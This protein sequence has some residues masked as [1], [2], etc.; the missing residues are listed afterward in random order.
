MLVF[1]HE[2]EQ[3]S[4]LANDK[5]KE[6]NE[7]QMQIPIPY[8]FNPYF[9][10]HQQIAYSRNP[11]E[12]AFFLPVIQRFDRFYSFG[13]SQLMTPTELAIDYQ[14]GSLIKTM[15]FE[16]HPLRVMNEQSVRKSN[17]INEKVLAQF[18]GSQV[19]RLRLQEKLDVL[20]ESFNIFKR[21]DGIQ[22][23]KAMLFEG[24]SRHFGQDQESNKGILSNIFVS[25]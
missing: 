6:R 14:V 24:E 16:L 4:T 3:Q 2:K 20:S 17:E 18:I 1:S 21:E 23:L 13:Q 9:Y 25:N 7:K 5:R 11:V 22:N 19:D 10:G 8:Q 12:S 15:L